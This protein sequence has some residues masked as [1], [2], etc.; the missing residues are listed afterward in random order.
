[1]KY[2]NLKIAKASE[3]SNPTTTTTTMLHKV[4]IITKKN[5]QGKGQT[6]LRKNKDY[7]MVYLIGITKIKDKDVS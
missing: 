3:Y 2:L 5:N 1:M 6:H 7:T 4:N